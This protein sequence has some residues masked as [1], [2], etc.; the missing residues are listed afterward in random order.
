MNHLE[1]LMIQI[2]KNMKKKGKKKARRFVTVEG[3][4][5]NYGTICRLREVVALAKKYKFRV[6]LDDSVGLG[7]V[8]ATGRGTLELLGLKVGCLSVICCNC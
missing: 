6:I 7:N 2:T 5:Q 3:I 1:E 8:G 4:Y